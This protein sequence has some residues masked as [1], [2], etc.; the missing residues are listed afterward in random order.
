MALELTL[1]VLAHFA[2]GLEDETFAETVLVTVS[3]TKCLKNRQSV[4]T[5]AEALEIG[6]M[7]T[8]GYFIGL[9]TDATNYVTI[10][11]GEDGADVVKL[12]A[13]E[14]AMFRLATATPYVIANTDECELRYMVVE[15]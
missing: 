14:V 7:T 1:N 9:N 2:K 11:D 12:E 8:P 5:S 4:G 3:G 10:R 6:D 13:G 15:D